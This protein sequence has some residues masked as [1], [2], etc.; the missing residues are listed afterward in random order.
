M[1]TSLLFQVE[2]L[3]KAGFKNPV[4][5]HKNISYCLNKLRV[6]YS[7]FCICFVYVLESS[8]NHILGRICVCINQARVDPYLILIEII[9]DANSFSLNM[10]CT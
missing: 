10:A 5:L 1:C 8:K 6:F 2:M 4:V 9:N 3:R 7:L